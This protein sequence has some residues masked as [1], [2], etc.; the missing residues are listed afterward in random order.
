M[1]LPRAEKAYEKHAWI[2]LFA[3]ATIFLVFAFTAILFG[4]GLSAF[5][6]GIPGG[7]DATKSLTGRTWDEIVTESPGI[8]NLIRA[9]SRVFGY[10]LLGFSVFGMALSGLGYRKGE[11][12]TWYVLWYLPA[13]LTG[14]AIHEFG[15]GFLAMPV[16]LLIVS[17]LGLFLPYRKF[18]PAKNPTPP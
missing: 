2:I 9:I 14:L 3:I 4:F 5:P 10:A 17:F 6:V 13:F 1:T 16:L 8:V 11:R 18:F 12:W 7:P 15:G